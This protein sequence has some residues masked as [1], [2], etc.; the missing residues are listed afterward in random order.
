MDFMIDELFNAFPRNISDSNTMN[1][2]VGVQNMA[3]PS[4][5]F[6]VASG[7]GSYTVSGENIARSAVLDRGAVRVGNSVIAARVSE[8][9]ILRDTSEEF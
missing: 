5:P 9:R 8:S 6:E 7:C 2:V 4:Q 3:T 1:V